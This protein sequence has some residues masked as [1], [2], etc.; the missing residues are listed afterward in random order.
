MTKDH[1]YFHGRGDLKTAAQGIRS[2]PW[3]QKEFVP[4][5]A[6]AITDLKSLLERFQRSEV[7]PEDLQEWADA[8]EGRNDLVDY[9]NPFSE[10]IA[11]VLFQLS[12]PEI[13]GE[14]TSQKA[15]ELIETLNAAEADDIFPTDRG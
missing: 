1:D 4:H 8:I 14:L 11:E 2:E 9:E 15:K 7:N 12:T 5:P 13:N 10:V 6:L 3:A